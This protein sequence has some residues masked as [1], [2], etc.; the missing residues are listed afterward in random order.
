MA[1]RKIAPPP[2]FLTMEII[3]ELIIAQ[4]AGPA[5]FPWPI[6][7]RGISKRE[8][9]VSFDIPNAVMV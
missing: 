1:V 2:H 8:E 9:Y 4:I 7:W 6:P 3:G 5:P